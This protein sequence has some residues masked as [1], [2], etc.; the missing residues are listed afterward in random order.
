MDE[1]FFTIM[2]YALIFFIKCIHGHMQACMYVY[3]FKY[4]VF[5]LR[6]TFS[7]ISLA[8]LPPYILTLLCLCHECSLVFI[9]YLLFLIFDNYIHPYAC[10]P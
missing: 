2:V 10:M 9:F 3:L 8:F 5:Y 1:S 7:L 6:C 4:V